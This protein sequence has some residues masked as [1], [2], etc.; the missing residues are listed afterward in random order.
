MDKTS[1]FNWI[2]E[3]ITTHTLDIIFI[4]DQNRRVR[5]TTPSFYDIL[6]SSPEEL[7]NLD[8]FDFVHPDDRKWLMDRHKRVIATQQKS[9]SEYRVIDKFGNIRHVECKTTP[10]PNTEDH[11]TVV[12]SRDITE[13][14]HMENELQRRKNRY[15]VLQQSLKNFSQDLSSVMKVS[16]LEDRLLHEVERIL[17]GSAPSIRIYHRENQTLEG[18]NL[19]EL[20]PLLPQLTVGKLETIGDKIFIKIGERMD[21]VYILSFHAS[22]ISETMESIWLETMVCFTVM[23]FENLNVIENLMYQLE[24]ALQSNETPQWVLRLLFNLQEQQRLNLSSDLHD[25][26]LQ[27]QIDLYRRL[28]LLLNRYDMEKEMKAQLKGIEQGLLD[29]I[30]QIRM[31]CNELRPP[32]LRELGLERALENLFEYTQVSSTFKI[33]FQ[34]ENMNNL[35]LNEELTIGIYRIIQELLNNATK[36]SKASM[37]SFQISHQD[38]LTVEYSDDG[39]GFNLDKLSPSFHSMGLS[40][41]R[42]RVQSLNGHIMFYSQPGHGVKV[43]IDFPKIEVKEN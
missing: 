6:G 41:M 14:K 18:S 40:S 31:T 13:R 38:T 33:M 20:E 12:V 4:V 15:E 16:D 21:C 17:T 23:V 29:T 24:S 22:S 42:Q 36:H 32:L 43:K 26:V 10:I 3:T 8:I 37:L 11:L 9:S 28:E 30:H 35:S 25:T 27:D 34:T 2:F 19:A 1:D 5:F 39:V 7:P